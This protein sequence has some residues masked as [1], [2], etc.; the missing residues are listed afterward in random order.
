MSIS[1]EVAPA[2]RQK[3]KVEI[4]PAKWQEFIEI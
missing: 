1:I 3:I 4:L 2:R